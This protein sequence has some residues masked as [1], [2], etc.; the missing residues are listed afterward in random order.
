[1]MCRIFIALFTLLYVLALMVFLTGTYGWFGQDTGPLAGIFLI[2]LGMPWILVNL[3]DPYDGYLAL[4]SPI[5]SIALL[6]IACQYFSKR[7]SS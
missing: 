1:M 7:H 2:P 5:V 3:G 4:L 6:W